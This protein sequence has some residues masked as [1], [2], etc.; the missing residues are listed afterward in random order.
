MNLTQAQL[1]IVVSY[2]V[3]AIL[4]VALLIWVLKENNKRE[5]KYQE[6][7]DKLADILNTEFL[8]IKNDVKDIK[9]YI[10]KK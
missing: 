4:F 10:L 6:T 1:D 5:L 3:F 7:I 8:A 2:G 9:N